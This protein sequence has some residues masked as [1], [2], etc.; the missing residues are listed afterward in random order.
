AAAARAWRR[1][2]PPL[3]GQSV[4]I[5]TGDEGRPPG[6]AALL[7][8]VVGEPNTLVGDPVDIAGSIPHHPVAV[9]AEVAHADVITPDDQNVRFI[10]HHKAFRRRSPGARCGRTRPPLIPGSGRP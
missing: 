7:P 5:L 1:A 2:G 8:V 9:A 3:S 6:G 4:G 10:A